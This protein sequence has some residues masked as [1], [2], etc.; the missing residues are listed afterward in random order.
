[1]FS[2]KLTKFGISFFRL[3]SLPD[4]WPRRKSR[5]GV[6]IWALRPRGSDTTGRDLSNGNR[7]CLKSQLCL[8]YLLARSLIRARSIKT[9]SRSRS[10]S[11]SLFRLESRNFRHD[12]HQ[13][14]ATPVETVYPGGHGKIDD[15]LPRL[16][17][18]PRGPVRQSF[19]S[20]RPAPS[21]PSTSRF[22]ST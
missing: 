20:V 18:V 7:G 19:R 10:L 21:Y 2:A 4:K 17:L 5:T 22:D 8:I 6:L 9:P 15:P 13:R 12:S 14:R 11:L 3:A 1:M 16:R